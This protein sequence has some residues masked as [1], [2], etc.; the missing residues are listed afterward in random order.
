M[1]IEN[2]SQGIVHIV[3]GSHGLAHYIGG[4]PQN[5]FE[6]L[7]FGI[8]KFISPLFTFGIM[9]DAENAC[10]FLTGCGGFQIILV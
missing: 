9:Q 3:G 6:F 2:K 1:L 5:L 10:K 7:F 8:H 4:V